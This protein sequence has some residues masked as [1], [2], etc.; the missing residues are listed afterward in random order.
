MNTSSIVDFGLQVKIETNY[1][2]KGVQVFFC[3]WQCVNR[4]WSGVSRSEFVFESQNQ[5]NIDPKK[6]DGY[7]YSSLVEK[8]NQTKLCL[9]YIIVVRQY[10]RVINTKMEFLKK[11]KKKL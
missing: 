9:V 4:W 1:F 3:A 6:T 8:R 10:I 2:F 5:F 11:K 7:L